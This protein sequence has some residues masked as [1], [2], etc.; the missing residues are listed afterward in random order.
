MSRPNKGS[1]TLVGI[2]FLPGGHVTTEVLAYIRSAD[3]F[4][5]LVDDP[6]ARLWLQGL[7]PDAVSLSSFA[8]PGK[9]LTD[10]CNAMVKRLLDEVRRGQTV[11]V[12]FAGHPG[13]GVYPASEA[14]RQAH[15]EGLKVRMVPA[16]STADSLFADLGI[17][18]AIGCQFFAA[19]QLLA[20]PNR[21]DPRSGL[22][23]YQPGA[24]G[25]T[26]Y[27]TDG[28]VP[29]AG[30][31]RLVE[32]LSKFYPARHEVIIYEA[33]MIPIYGP[34]VERVPL[35]RLPRA[36]LTPISTLYVPPAKA[37]RGLF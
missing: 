15:A 35:I 21:L 5:F 19:N 3:H 1:L 31:R 25:I 17:D 11:C 36:R 8:R 29:R 14:L 32:R 34:R 33:A 6:V 9:L 12:A 16:I 37:T 24:V 4:F 26:R 30:L 18:P 27:R 22:I 20:K 28:R 10:C 2:G 13:V 23:V 7:R